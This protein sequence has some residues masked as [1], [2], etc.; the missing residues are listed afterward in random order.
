MAPRRAA[1]ATVPCSWCI[2]PDATHKNKSKNTDEKKR[3]ESGGE[4]MFTKY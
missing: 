2:L 1:D 4:K 3:V